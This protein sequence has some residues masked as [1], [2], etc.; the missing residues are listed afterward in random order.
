MKPEGH[1]ADRLGAFEEIDRERESNNHGPDPISFWPQAACY[2]IS[3]ILTVG[4][5]SSNL[6][7]G[8]C[9]TPAANQF[10][11]CAFFGLVALSMFLWAGFS[12]NGWSAAARF[13]ISGAVPVMFPSV[14]ALVQNAN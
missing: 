7:I 12:R 11:I 13:L 3:F 1:Q 14:I 2:S 5:T 4:W 9:G 10:S 8:R 6:W